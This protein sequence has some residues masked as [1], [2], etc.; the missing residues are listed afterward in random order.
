MLRRNWPGQFHRSMRKPPGKKSNQP[1]EV[2]RMLVFNPGEV[3]ELDAAEFAAV[4]ADIGISLIEVEA[5]IREA[6]GRVRYR[7]V[8]TDGHAPKDESVE[9]AATV[10]TKPTQ[11]TAPVPTAPVERAKPQA[12]TKN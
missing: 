5:E 9:A 3:V 11:V 2:V 7:P 8:K 10:A 1:G 4:Q 6:D 12:T